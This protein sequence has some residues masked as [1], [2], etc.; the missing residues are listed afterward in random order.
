M[1]LTNLQL[2]MGFDQ[3]KIGYGFDQFKIGYSDD[4]FKLV[5]HMTNFYWLFWVIQL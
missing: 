1:H 2:V 5:M 3:L 4:Q